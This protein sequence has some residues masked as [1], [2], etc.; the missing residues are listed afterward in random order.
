MPETDEIIEA[1]TL[2]DLGAVPVYV[3]IRRPDGRQVEVKLKA[4]TEAQMWEIRRAVKWPRPPVKDLRKVNGQVVQDLDYENEDYLNGLNEANRRLGLKVLL[5]C[6][7]LAIPGETEAEQMAALQDT[8][9]Q[10]AVSVLV[11]AAQHLNIVGAEE[12]ARV[13]HSFR[14]ARGAG[15]PGDGALAADAGPVAGAGAG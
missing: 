9:G 5:G 8:L 7:Q 14:S 12:L 11:E 15:A 3:T 13:A 2:A 1:R 4:L 6:L 10:Y